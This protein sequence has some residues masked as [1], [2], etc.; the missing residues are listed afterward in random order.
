M[1]FYYCILTKHIFNSISV[2]T[3]LLNFKR[4]IHYANTLRH[5]FMHI[6]FPRPILSAYFDFSSEV[7]EVSVYLFYAYGCKFLVF[8]RLTVIS[9]G[10]TL[11]EIIDRWQQMYEMYKTFRLKSIKNPKLLANLELKYSKYLAKLY[12]LYKIDEDEL[13]N[14]TIKFE[15]WNSLC[16]LPEDDTQ[17]VQMIDDKEFLLQLTRAMKECPALWDERNVNYNDKELRKCMWEDVAAT[18]TQFNRKYGAVFFIM[19]Q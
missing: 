18:L 7:V 1:T 5:L 12:F 19:T 11:E 13:R 6:P 15:D 3:Q 16:D 14:E 9:V 2:S 17:L 10:N 8:K 4:D